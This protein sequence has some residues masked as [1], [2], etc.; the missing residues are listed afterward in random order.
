MNLQAIVQNVGP[1]VGR[2]VGFRGSTVDIAF[3]AGSLP[4]ILGGLRL[5]IG[6]KT[7]LAEVQAHLDACTVRAVA[8]EHAEALVAGAEATSLGGAIRVPVGAS[9]LG[10]VFDA[11]GQPLDGGQAGDLRWPIHRAPPPLEKQ[12]ARQSAFATGIK[13]VDLLAPLVRGGKTAM[14]GGA[15]V[16]KTVLVMEL[17][18]AAI[19]RHAG[20]AVFA[21]VG[22]RSREGHELLVEAKAAGIDARAA[23]VFG[24]MGEPPGAR[25]RAGFTALTMAEYFR[26]ALGEDVLLLVDNFFR[27]I[28]AGSEI[29][30]QLGRLPTRGGYQ[31]TLSSEIAAF[32]DRI[33]SVR[34]AAVTAILAMY[35]PADDFTDPAV[36]ETFAHLD[37]TLVLSRAMAAEGL[38]PAIDPLASTSSLLVPAALGERHCRIADAVRGALAR[39]ADLQEIIALLGIDEL[40]KEDRTTVARARRLQRFLTQPFGATSV[41]TGIAGASIP[42]EATLAGCSAILDGG[43]DALAEGALYMV[44]TLDDARAKAARAA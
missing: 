4:P 12:D 11:V 16:G 44:G 20:A 8:L 29:S 6:A 9:V 25:W 19:G 41:F 26:D 17:M 38:Y 40:S 28:Q 36:A 22:E 33:A 2:V 18:R 39:Y 13:V 31:P 42:L 5:R 43:A 21:G 27:F 35:V 3:Q 37:S 32:Q 23:F 1:P 10:R 30:S 7:L 14:F 34:G 24:Q 15:G